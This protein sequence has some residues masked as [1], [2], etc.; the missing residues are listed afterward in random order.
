MPATFENFGISFQYPDNWSLEREPSREGCKAVSVVSPDGAFWTI[1][2]HPRLTDPTKL[3]KAT[4]EALEEEYSPVEVDE[5]NET[6]GE[7]EALG[8]DF[9]FYCLDM[10]GAAQI[11]CFTTSQAVYAIYCQAEDRE[12]A[13]LTDVFRA[14]TVSL[15]DSLD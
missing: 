7:H 8:S 12:F 14:M 6:I 5:V 2:I 9:G 11:R 13:Q 10:I 3:I 15:L 1:A 4:E